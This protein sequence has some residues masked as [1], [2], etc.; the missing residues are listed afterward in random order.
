MSYKDSFERAAE[1]AREALEHM[2][3]LE[4][5]PRPDNFEVWYAFKAEIDAELTRKLGDLLEEPASFDES[6]FDDI[7]QSYFGEDRTALLDTASGKVEAVIATTLDSIGDASSNAKDYGAKLADFTGDMDAADAAKAQ[8]LVAKLLADTK[9]TMDR[10]AQLEA[11]LKAAGDQIETLRDNL[12]DARKAS[13]TDGLT[14]LPNR[15]SFDLGLQA[16]IERAKERSGPLSLIV[17]DVD[18]FKRFNDTYGHLVGDEVLK[19][20]SR[21]LRSMVKGGDK[22]ARYGGEEFCVLLPTTDI[23]GAYVVAEK[24]REAIAAKA[25]K[26]ARTGESYGQITLSFGC[27]ALGP[28][29]TAETLYERADAALYMA[30]RSGRNRTCTDQQIGARQAG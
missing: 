14:G 11:E 13:E 16:E 27:A 12:N 9:I 4:I 21:V 23:Q 19:L 20:V 26:S 1:L 28:D 3:A 22:T 29:D 18:F 25:L 7:K 6:T 10:N 8:A 24:I 17:A 5:P 15:R 2:N 30:K